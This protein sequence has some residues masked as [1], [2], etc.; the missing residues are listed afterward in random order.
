MTYP[1]LPK[2]LVGGQG[3]PQWF[4]PFDQSFFP[5]ATTNVIGD[6]TAAILRTGV[7]RP[8]LSSLSTDG[9][10]QIAR[11]GPYALPKIVGPRFAWDMIDPG[12]RIIL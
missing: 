6:A 12:G 7:I 9:G 3:V 8:F 5:A 2:K 4:C 11:H 10:G 1:A